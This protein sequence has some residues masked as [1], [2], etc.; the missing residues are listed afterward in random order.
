V[1]EAFDHGVGFLHDLWPTL[2]EYMPDH[3]VI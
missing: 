3:S 1:Q 2:L